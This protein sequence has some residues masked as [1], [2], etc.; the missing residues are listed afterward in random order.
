MKRIIV[1]FLLCLGLIAT[2]WALQPKEFFRV[3]DYTHAARISE[4]SRALADGHFPV[5]WSQNFGYGYGM[6]LFNFYAPLPYYVGSAFYSMG[7]DIVLT[8]KLLFVL[9]NVLVLLGSYKFGRL[10][11]G[12]SGAV[13][14][15]ILVALA[16]YRALNLYIRGALSEAWALSILPWVFYYAILLIRGAKQ[17]WIWFA[18]NLA[19]LALTH[20]ITLIL[21]AP[22]MALFF[23]FEWIRVSYQQRRARWDIVVKLA[24][25]GLLAVGLA[26]FYLFPAFLEKNFTKLDD[27]ILDY[28]FSYQLHF[29]YIRQ[30]FNHHWQ[31]GGSGWGPQDDVSFGLGIGQLA[32]LGF[33]ALVSIFVLVTKIKSQRITQLFTK[34][35]FWVL[36]ASASCL[37]FSLLMT[38]E[39]TLM[40]WQAVPL[41]KY[42]QFPWRWLT[43]A[44]PF[45]GILGALGT[46]LLPKKILRYSAAL[47]LIAL[48]I[49]INA[50]YFRPEKYLQKASDYYSTTS[51]GIRGGMSSILPDYIPKGLPKKIISATTVVANA[52][53]LAGTYTVITE[54]TQQK[55]IKVSMKS[56]G[57]VVWA[58]VDFPGWVVEID[59]VA[60]QKEVTENGLISV[61]VP[62]GEH[63]VGL[64]LTLTEIQYWS[65]LVTLLAVLVIIIGLLWPTTKS[66]VKE[67]SDVHTN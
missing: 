55:L 32:G 54:R 17:A 8:I 65:Q 64:L 29:L 3:H 27:Y 40:I 16:P 14:V 62:Q 41:L 37:C 61:T 49:S 2:S 59:G 11:F 46:Q 1:G 21:A 67:V 56:E 63:T 36:I 12:R 15:A 22:V 45:I 9:S 19:A 39:K 28:Y 30:F 51:E 66:K 53:T 13:L 35:W 6:P 24:I 26:A 4:M 44:V 50:S 31:Y 23:V 18:I 52:D 5:R 43:I 42:A 33:S 47:L 25:A 60:Q 20:N 34:R 10:Y 57:K 7:F 38:L 58:V 48:T